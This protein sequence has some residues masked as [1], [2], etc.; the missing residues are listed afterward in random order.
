MYHR[1]RVQL[2]NRLTISAVLP[3]FVKVVKVIKL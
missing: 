3:F 2:S 1:A